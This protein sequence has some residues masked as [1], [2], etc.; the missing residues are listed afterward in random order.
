MADARDP[1]PYGNAP[2][3]RGDP[4]RTYFPLTKSDADIPQ[5]DIRSLYVGGGGDVYAVAPDDGT[6][7][8]VAFLA[9]P[10]GSILPIEARRITNATTATNL[11][12][13]R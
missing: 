10:A 12:G 5:G 9:V 2:G 4:A 8:A 6:N 3:E 13:M 7:T 1:F 11:V